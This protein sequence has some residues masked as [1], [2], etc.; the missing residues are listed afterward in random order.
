MLVKINNQQ[1]FISLCQNA[2]AGDNEGFTYQVG[3][4]IWLICHTP[5]PKF[6]TLEEY[7]KET[8]IVGD[9]TVLDKLF[10]CSPA[11]TPLGYMHPIDPLSKE[12]WTIIPIGEDSVY[13]CSVSHNIAIAA[14]EE[15]KR[16]YED[17]FP[18]WSIQEEDPQWE[19]GF[20]DEE[21]W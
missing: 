4:E 7:L 14:L 2:W 13:F 11:I 17:I 3:E 1:E 20:D 10:C 16:I 15:K 19:M 18:S 9:T 5:D 6:S 21:P 12:Y 8:K